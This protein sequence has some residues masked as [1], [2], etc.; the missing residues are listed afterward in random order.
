MFGGLAAPRL[1]EQFQGDE[2]Y[3]KPRYARAQI[4]SFASA[5]ELYQS[6]NCEPPTTEQGLSALVRKPSEGSRPRRWKAYLEMKCVPLDPWGNRYIY[7]A[8]GPNG[9]PFLVICLGA[10]GK[11]GGHD[12]DADLMAPLRSPASSRVQ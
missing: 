5:L 8:P 11:R 10:D 6:D 3:R 12:L 9:E 7:A 1:V 2:P 4:G